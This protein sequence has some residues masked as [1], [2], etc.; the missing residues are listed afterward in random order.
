MKGLEAAKEC[1][2]I[3]GMDGSWDY[4]EYMRGMYNG[5]ALAIACIEDRRPV[6]KDFVKSEVKENG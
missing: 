6:Y 1:L 3:Q 5:L 4:S 2:K